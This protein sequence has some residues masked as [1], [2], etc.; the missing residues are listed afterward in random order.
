[1]PNSVDAPSF[2]GTS[3]WVRGPDTL[4]ADELSRTA[5]QHGVLIEPG[6]VYFARPQ[7]APRNMFRLGFS[8]IETDKIEP[9]EDQ[10]LRRRQFQ[11]PLL[12]PPLLPP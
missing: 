6:S 7:K 2:G 5:L 10:I 8:S 12:D 1:M 4:D 9:G 3:F 11:L